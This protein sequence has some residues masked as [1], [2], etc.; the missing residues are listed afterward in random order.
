MKIFLVLLLIA[1][2][3]AAQLR[4][5]RNLPWW[6]GGPFNGDGYCDDDYNTA[7][8]KYDSGDCCGPNV[9]KHFCIECKCISGGSTA[10]T[11]TT[12]TI[13]TTTTTAST[14]TTATTT[15]TTGCAK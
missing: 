3:S 7:A 6:C 14:T 2:A 8:C 10:T 13:T 4:T 1:I 15:D 11:T 12:T 9:K 5:D